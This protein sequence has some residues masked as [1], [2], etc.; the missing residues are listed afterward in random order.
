MFKN[1][2]PFVLV[3]FPVYFIFWIPYIYCGLK[4]SG[5]TI[6]NRMKNI[7]NQLLLLLMSTKSIYSLSLM[8]IC[9][10]CWLEQRAMVWVSSVETIRKNLSL[11]WRGN[12]SFMKWERRLPWTQTTAGFA[13]RVLPVLPPKNRL[14][15]PSGGQYWT[16]VFFSVTKLSNKIS[17]EKNAIDVSFKHKDWRAH[18]AFRG[19]SLDNLDMPRS[20]LS[21]SWSTSNSTSS[22]PDYSRPHSS[23]SGSSSYQ[24]GRPG[25]ATLPSSQSMSSL[26]QSWSPSAATPEPRAPPRNRYSL[27]KGH[28]HCSPNTL[29][30]WFSTGSLI[31]AA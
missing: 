25:S 14:I 7:L 15:W 11:S 3:Y 8:M 29:K 20:S 21:S 31:I 27:L 18:F 30:Q 12:R 2:W 17:N 4:H 19:E 9:V 6:C 1:I 26:R 13:S 5:P 10:C 16:A 23:L 22:I 24:S 28:F